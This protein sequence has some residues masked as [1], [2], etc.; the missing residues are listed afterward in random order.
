MAMAEQL[1]QGR[2]NHMIGISVSWEG[3]DDVKLEFEGPINT[4]WSLYSTCV[5]YPTCMLYP[6]VC[7]SN[8]YCCK[9]FTSCC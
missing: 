8:M 1:V 2:N 6:N 3:N 9:C 5:L 4:I 7:I